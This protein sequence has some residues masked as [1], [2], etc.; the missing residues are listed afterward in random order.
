MQ[1]LYHIIIKCKHIK[2]SSKHCISFTIF[3]LIVDAVINDVHCSNVSFDY[4]K[5]GFYIAFDSTNENESREVS[6]LIVVLQ[7][8]NKK[9]KITIDRAAV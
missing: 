1:Q 7:A 6:T 8:F 3:D 5:T 4:S 9:S 2:L